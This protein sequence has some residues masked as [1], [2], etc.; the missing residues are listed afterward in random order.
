MAAF[1][2]S[3]AHQGLSYIEYAALRVTWD[4]H[5]RFGLDEIQAQ[6]GSVFPAHSAVTGGA[7]GVARAG[8]NSSTTGSIRIAPH[9]IIQ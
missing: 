5:F 4:H 7:P 6:S 3:G 2:A 8:L 1:G 9:I